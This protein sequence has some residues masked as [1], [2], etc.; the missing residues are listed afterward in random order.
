[1]AQNIITLCPV[2]ASVKSQS[3]TLHRNVTWQ[4]DSVARVHIVCN[5]SMSDASSLFIALKCKDNCLEIALFCLRYNCE[6]THLRTTCSLRST[7]SCPKV[8]HLNFGQWGK[9]CQKWTFCHWSK[10]QPK[11]DNKISTHMAYAYLNISLRTV[12]NISAK[13]LCILHF[14]FFSK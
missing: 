8:T 5:R 10:V 2:P 3:L 6:H 9:V 11:P 12:I 4:T 13:F 7:S 14:H 1:M